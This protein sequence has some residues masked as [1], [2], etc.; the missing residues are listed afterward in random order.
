MAHYKRKRPR[1]SPTHNARGCIKTYWLNTW[2]R[3]WDVV[4]HT[5]PRR[6]RDKATMQAVKSGWIEA[7][8]A[9]WSVGNKPHSYY[10]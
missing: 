9:N 1:T 6:R 4:F 10:W 5:R 3:W 8:A 7:D 2:P